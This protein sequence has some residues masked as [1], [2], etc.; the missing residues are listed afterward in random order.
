MLTITKFADGC[1]W[2]RADPKYSYKLRPSPHSSRHFSRNFGC[3]NVFQCLQP[4]KSIRHFRQRQDD[5][6]EVHPP[7]VNHC[8]HTFAYGVEIAKENVDLSRGAGTIGAARASAQAI[9][10]SSPRPIL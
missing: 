9:E 4:R 1:E 2:V 10:G 3:P 8:P 6:S 7:F 5:G